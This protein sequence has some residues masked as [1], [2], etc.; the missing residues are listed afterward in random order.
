MLDEV[1]RFLADAPPGLRRDGHNVMLYEDDVPT[2]EVGVQVSATFEPDGVVVSSVLAGGLVA[3]ARHTG[4][5]DRLGETHDAVC[6]WCAE[7]GH[8]LSRVRWEIYGDPD[9]ASGDFDVEVFWAIA[10]PSAAP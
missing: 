6:A 2:V 5:I 1:W 7:R 8:P 3:T 9:P 4:G 10:G